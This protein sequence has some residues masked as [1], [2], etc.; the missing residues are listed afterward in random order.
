MGLAVACGARAGAGFGATVEGADG[1]ADGG[2]A[3][4]GCD[5]GEESISGT[6]RFAGSL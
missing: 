6:A 1:A 2:L 4:I 3:M 5:G